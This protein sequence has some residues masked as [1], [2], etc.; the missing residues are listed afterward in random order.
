MKEWVKEALGAV[1]LVSMMFL[2]LF[3]G[4]IIRSLR[5]PSL[6]M[7]ALPS[8]VMDKPSAVQV[9]CRPIEMVTAEI[10]AAEVVQ[11]APESGIVIPEYI[12]EITEEVG[13]AYHISPELLQAIAWRESRF[14]PDAVSSNGACFGVM[15]VSEKW[16][17]DRLLP[18]EKLTDP[19]ANIR[20]AAEY[21]SELF[22]RY[23][24]L[25]IVLMKYNGDSRALEPR[26][27]SG[28]ARDVMELAEELEEKK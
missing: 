28:Y 3:G 12:V 22:E 9:V 14:D 6:A 17:S 24:E 4:N 5:E 16:H 11:S 1:A 18:G 10:V 8:R 26:Y 7:A 19:Q 27:I 13:Q 15:Q 2:A 21:L 20:V 25:D 23:R